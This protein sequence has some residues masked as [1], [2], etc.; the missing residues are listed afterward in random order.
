MEAAAGVDAVGE[1]PS[2][3]VMALNIGG[4][5]PRSQNA[6]GLGKGEKVGKQSLPLSLQG[7]HSLADTL[8]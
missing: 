3:T 4:R 1:R 6:G 7:E 5:G 8:N 2:R